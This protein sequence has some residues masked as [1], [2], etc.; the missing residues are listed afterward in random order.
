MTGAEYAV[1][2]LVCEKPSHGYELEAV[3]EQR[4]MRE[5]TALAFSS[6]YFV[7][8]KLEKKGLVTVQT[9]A[10]ERSH[11]GKPRRVYR[12]TGEGF[13]AL[14]ARTVKALAEPHAQH[15]SVLL[16]LANWPA[17]DRAQGIASLKTRGDALKARQRELTARRAAVAAFV[18]AHVLAIFDHG[19][20]LIAA[21]RR[22][23]KSTLQQLE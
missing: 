3:I 22:W 23:L 2:S 15:S 10:Q 5:W 18:P 20:T 11:P 4:G 1:L 21:E 14:V 16:G 9:S 19:I 17:L 13:A 7:L 6:I 12:A 8:K